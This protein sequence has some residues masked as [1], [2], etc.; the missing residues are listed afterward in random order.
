MLGIVL[1]ALLTMLALRALRRDRRDYGRFKAFTDTADRQR[2]YRRWLLETLAVFGLSCAVILVLAFRYVGALLEA[3]HRW[4]AFRWFAGLVS[5]TGAIIPGIAIAVAC[6]LVVGTVALVAVAR[7]SLLDD[8]DEVPTLGDI[9]ALLPRNRR[10]LLYGAGLS[11]NAGILEELLFR[12]AVPALVFAVSGSALVA[13]VG[14]VLLF[15]ALHSYQGIPGMAGALLIGA[16]L[17]LL[18]LTT[19]SILVPMIA[20]ALLDLRSLV[21]IPVLVYGVHRLS[22]VTSKV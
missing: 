9:G 18:Y 11:L 1:L 13:V 15:A 10:E 14:S 6:L 2:M 19:G 8:G 21:L 7:R 3:V 17:M 20:H 4:Q 12:L 22:G 16:V 5:S